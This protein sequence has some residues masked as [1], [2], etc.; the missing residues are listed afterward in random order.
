MPRI[1]NP[2]PGKPVPLTV[3]VPQSDYIALREFCTERTAATGTRMIHRQAM[4][5]A[6]RLLL[7]QPRAKARVP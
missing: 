5:D 4:L 6:L 3:L 7:G 2:P 1:T